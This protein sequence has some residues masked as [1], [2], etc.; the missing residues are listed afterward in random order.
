[1]Y[2]QYL[3]R[4]CIHIQNR[5]NNDNVVSHNTSIRDNNKLEYRITKNVVCHFISK[6][7]VF[8]VEPWQN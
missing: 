8:M 1:M 2:S 4:Y 5:Y 6:D 3:Q 7:A